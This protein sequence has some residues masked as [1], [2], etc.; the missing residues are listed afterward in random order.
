MAEYIQPVLFIH[1]ALD[2]FGDFGVGMDVP[3]RNGCMNSA[4][5]KIGFKLGFT[6][7]GANTR[8]MFFKFTYI[9]EM[10][11]HGGSFTHMF[12]S[13]QTRQRVVGDVNH[14]GIDGTDDTWTISPAG[15]TFLPSCGPVNRGI[16]NHLIDLFF[17]PPPSCDHI[18]FP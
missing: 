11:R 10:F 7:I 14:L 12:T 4:L 16:I 3:V 15:R 9:L 18:L 6:S 1:A 13:W 17:H 8:F 5:R 2:G